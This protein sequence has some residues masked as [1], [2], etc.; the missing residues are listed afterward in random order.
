MNK[1]NTSYRQILLAGLII[2]LAII[3]RA[4]FWTGHIFSDDAYYSYLSHTLFEGDFVKDYLGYPVF[5]LRIG[6]ISLTSFSFSLFGSNEFAT[7]VFPFLFSIFNLILAY[8]LTHLI[9]N[10]INTALVAVLLIALFPTD[11]LFATMNFPDLIN[12]FFINLGIY[13]L[14]NSYYNKNKKKALVG[15]IFLFLSMQFKESIY[16][17]L[18]LL[19]ILLVY[20]LIKKKQ[21]TYQ[22]VIGILFVGINLLLEGFIYLFLHGDFFHRITITSLNFQYSFYDFFP[23]TAQ[24]YSGS[25]N[26]FKILFDQIFLINVKSIYLRR[27]YLFLPIIASIQS[28]I[29]LNKKEHKFLIYWFVGLAVLMITFTTSFTEFK[30]LDLQRSWY[31]YPLLMPMIVLSAQFVL[32]FKKQISILLLIIYTLGCL[33]MC[34]HYD[35][36]FDKSNLI[37]LKSFLREN[38]HKKI[39]TDHFTKY[40][41]DLIRSYEATSKSNR[42]LGKGFNFNKVEK[43]DWILYSKKH[44]DELKLQKHEF[45]DFSILNSMSFKKISEYND[46]IFYEKTVQ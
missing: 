17:V 7:V 25:K 43:G 46:F 1:K 15:G 37:S 28:F 4:Y 30:P 23:Y 41:V 22:I 44:I 39:F 38:S 11:V 33:I 27:F 8:K 31:V 20:S 14:L 24:K 18:I 19:L 13:F 21:I 16:Y 12:V 5:P 29:H 45:P 9:T 6:Q 2:I 34:H 10:K 32:R 42:I 35:I 3:V 36:Y 40:S 26:Y